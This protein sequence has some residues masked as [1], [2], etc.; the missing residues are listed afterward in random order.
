MVRASTRAQREKGDRSGS[1]TGD[2][3]SCPCELA[4]TLLALAAEH[5][6]QEARERDG[7]RG[8]EHADQ[9]QDGQRVL[10]GGRVVVVAEQ[11][12]PADR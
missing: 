11:Q 8:P 12:Q 7:G 3:G 10:A 9:P 5:H 2:A 6:E 1:F 4:A